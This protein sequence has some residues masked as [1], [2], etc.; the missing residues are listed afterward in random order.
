PILLIENKQTLEQQGVVDDDVVAAQGHDKTGE[1]AG[2][3]DR[4]LLPQFRLHAVDDSVDHGGG[5]VHNAGAHAVD[6]VC[7]DHLSRGLQ[8]DLGELGGAAA[9]GVQGDPEARQ[10]DAADVVARRVDD[11][12]GGGCPHVDD[13][14]GGGVLPQGR[15][16]VHDHVASGGLGVVHDDV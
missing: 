13:D 3:D 6:G 15:H 8:A 5:S 4:G 12:H 1:A 2:G 16:G 9:Q 7:A 14:E 11:G 10:D